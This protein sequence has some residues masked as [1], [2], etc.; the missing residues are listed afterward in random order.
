MHP[1]TLITIKY[2]DA[3]AYKLYDANQELVIPTD[4]DKTIERWAEPTGRY[5]GEYR[6]EGVINQ[7]QFWITPGCTLFIYPRDAIMLAVRLEW[8]VAE[9]YQEDGIGI[10]T[11]RMAAALG[12]ARAD[13]KVVQ[14]YEGSVIV[15]FQ[16]FSEEGDTDSA[17]TLQAIESKF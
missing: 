10:F 2:P 17:A 6:F 16:V 15:E 5:C 7:L 12:I 9:F 11:D 8:T 4:W 14:V 3:G 1:G 13:L